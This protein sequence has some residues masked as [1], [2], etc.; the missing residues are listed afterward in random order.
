M[1]HYFLIAM[2]ALF[3]SACAGTAPR[4]GAGTPKAQEASVA[5]S[6]AEAAAEKADS[7]GYLWRDT[8]S[9]LEQARAAAEAENFEKAIELADEARRQADLAYQQYLDERE[10]AAGN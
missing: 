9:M 5:I 10:T 6:E 4:D 8:E 3:L 7:V 2:L 1:K